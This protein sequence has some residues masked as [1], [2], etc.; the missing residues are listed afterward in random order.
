MKGFAA[1]AP[2][3]HAY[4]NAGVLLLSPSQVVFDELMA[5]GAGEHVSRFGHVVDCTEQGLLNSYYNGDAGREVTKLNKVGRADVA[6]DW[7]SEA[8]PFAV[9]WITHV[10]PKPWLV[11]DEAEGVPS[12]CDPVVYSY[13]ERIWER[14]AASTN[15]VGSQRGGWARA[16][17]RRENSR[18]RTSSRA[19]LL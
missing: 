15:S 8:A 19:S 18:I 1:E 7:A 11:A 10:C 3:H 17:G 14:L 13:W 16:R 5:M 9:H 12:H 6:A 4:F 2:R